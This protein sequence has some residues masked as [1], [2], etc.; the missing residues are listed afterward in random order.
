MLRSKVKISKHNIVATRVNMTYSLDENDEQSR[1]IEMAWEDRTPFEAIA[2][3]YGL[4]EGELI[5]F[6]RQVLKP[7]SFF[8]WRKRVS[9][10]KTKHVALRGNNVSRSHCPSQYKFSSANKK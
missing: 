7:K 3:L 4:N 2:L 10:R 1:I 8:R 5:T 9:G 6:M